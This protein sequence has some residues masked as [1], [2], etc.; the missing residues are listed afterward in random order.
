[1]IVSFK[2]SMTESG[3]CLMI[4]IPCI[5]N[6][7]HLAV[8]ELLSFW[9]VWVGKLNESQARHSR[10]YEIIRSKS[11]G[12]RYHAKEDPGKPCHGVVLSEAQGATQPCPT[13]SVKLTAL[14]EQG[15]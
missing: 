9:S 6:D 4:E 14:G 13:G 5:S 11:A 2:I 12:L 8:S 10:L 7:L 15:V 1:M 3:K